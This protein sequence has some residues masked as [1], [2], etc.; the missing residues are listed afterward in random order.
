[1]AAS[2]AVHAALL[3]VLAVHAPRLRV[4]Q[5]QAGPPEAVIPVL[6]MPRVPPPAAQPG[7]K[8]QPIRLHR[9]PQ[10]FAP[11]D[12][13]VAPLVVPAAEERPSAPSAPGPR[14]LNIA[15]AEDAIAVNARK[16]LRSRLGCA[17]AA[18]LGLT[19]EER[20]KCEDDLAAGARQADYLGT[21]I[22]ADKARGLAAAARRRENDYTYMRSTGGPGTVG[23]GP[24]ANGN[25]VGRGNNLPGRT[26]TEIGKI[27]GSD[28]PT[29]TVPF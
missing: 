4:P 21:G 1:M 18:A 16:A 29:S 9:R 14:T 19:R 8:P 11:E 25:A 3:T 2:L 24:S 23:A 22:D 13:T 12:T 26:S 28:K 20:R 27:V 5:E 7:A 17:N 6:I 10:R 15:P